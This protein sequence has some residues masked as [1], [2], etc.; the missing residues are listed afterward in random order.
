MVIYGNVYD[1]LIVGNTFKNAANGCIVRD[2][3]SYNCTI[4][5]NTAAAAANYIFRGGNHYNDLIFN[6]KYSDTLLDNYD[7]PALYNCWTDCD[8]SK[9]NSAST[10]IVGTDPKVRE[11]GTLKTGSHCINAGSNDYYTATQKSTLRLTDIYGKSRV[12]NKI[13]DIGCTEN[14]AVA[15]MVL[16][17]R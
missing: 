9:K 10:F 2:G 14:P 5:S 13:I 7:T 12:L 4:V 11:D 16:I 3:N 1:C 8:F 17:V 6:N 15:G